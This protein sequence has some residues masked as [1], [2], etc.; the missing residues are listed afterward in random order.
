VPEKDMLMKKRKWCNRIT[1]GVL[2]YVFVIII[3]GMP[4]ADRKL[5]SGHSREV[6]YGEE[7]FSRFVYRL[8]NTATLTLIVCGILATALFQYVSCLWKKTNIEKWARRMIMMT[9]VL[10]CDMVAIMILCATIIVINILITQLSENDICREFARSR[11]VSYTGILLI[12]AYPFSHLIMFWKKSKGLKINDII[13]MH[14]ENEYKKLHNEEKY[15]EAEYVLGK[16]C[17]L[18]PKNLKAWVFRSSLCEMKL[19]KP[20]ESMEYL[21]NAIK[22]IKENL[23]ISNKEKATFEHFVGLILIQKHQPE[24]GMSHI[25]RALELDYDKSRHETMKKLEKGFCSE[26][27]EAE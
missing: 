24:E 18:D 14:Y 8:D 7:A 21:Q 16:I 15:E 12:F 4:F 1:I 26:D 9:R 11:C 2:V 10:V 20:E 19:G 3:F 5:V 23:D 6:I 25:K 27:S 17:E 22:N 13:A